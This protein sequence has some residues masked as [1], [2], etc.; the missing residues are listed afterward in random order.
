MFSIAHYVQIAEPL[1]ALK[2]KKTQNASVLHDA[3]LLLTPL[4]SIEP[5]CAVIP[6][7]WAPGAALIQKTR[8]GT[9]EV[10]YCS[11]LNYSATELEY[12]GRGVEKWRTCAE[13]CL[14]TVVT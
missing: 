6:A 13:G 10:A 3:E 2:K 5:T 8:L 4:K 1:G 9:E 11:R 14:F 12:A 7:E